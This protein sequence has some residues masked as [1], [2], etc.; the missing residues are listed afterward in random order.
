MFSP[1]QRTKGIKVTK[2]IIV[3][4]GASM[5]LA[6]CA[7]SP[8]KAPCGAT[9]LTLSSGVDCDPKPINF[10]NNSTSKFLFID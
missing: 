2:K 3:L 7:H 1:D 4:I 5:A 9:Q 6:S 10:A 8:V